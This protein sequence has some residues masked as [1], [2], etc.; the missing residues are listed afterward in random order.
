MVHINFKKID[1]FASTTS[2]GNPAA[3]VT[4]ET[5]DALSERQML[6]IAKELKGFVSEVGFI[7][8][9]ENT[10][11]RLRFFS[12]VRE[13][14]FC[15]HATIAIVHDAIC[16]SGDLQNKKNL[17]IATQHDIL[18]VDNRYLKERSV[19]ISAPQPRFSMANCSLDEV[20]IALRCSP[21]DL[22]SE[23]AFEIV[24][25][26]LETLIVPMAGIRAI[27]SVSPDL[28][29]LNAFCKRI[30]ADILILFS[31]ETTAPENRFRTRVFAPTFG[32]LEDPATGSGNSALGHYLLKHGLW[33]GETI[34]IEQ[35]GIAE[36]PNIVRLYAREDEAC[37]KQVW[38]GGGAVLR[39]EGQ[40]YLH[41]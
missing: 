25:A 8:P 1:A 23:R 39:L 24:N 28:E 7:C 35:N 11:L 4:L 19:F 27:L 17:S 5:M 32:Y 15:G 31:D 22:D 2:S 20:A 36:K 30:G 18:T 16:R 41:D 38:F 21:K 6:Q 37:V 13:V 40:Y 3:V 34:N 26:G 29:T 33:S 14:A 10:D 9:G 12:S